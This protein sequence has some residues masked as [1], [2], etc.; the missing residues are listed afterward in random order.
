MSE[1]VEAALHAAGIGPKLKAAL[2]FGPILGFVA[3][4]LVVREQTYTLAGRDWD[5]FVL[6][7]GGFVPV[8]LAS[9]AAMWRLTG[10]ITPVQVL[11]LIIMTL[12]GALTVGFNDERFFK[13]RTTVV[14]L[15]LSA[16]L[17]VGLARGQAW[18]SGVMG[19]MVALSPAGWTYLTRRFAAV[20]LVLAGANE[21]I[22]RNF[23]TDV[24]VAYDTFIMPVA[25]FGYLALSI[26]RART[27]GPASDRP[28]SEPSEPLDAG[29]RET[30]NT[31]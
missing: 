11:T 13:M 6:L 27:L 1:P 21:A 8:V 17:W 14:C 15:T 7:V 4:Y 16:I 30:G 25:F 10:R 20:L 31:T 24:W 5:G 22:W 9:S 29:Q 18:L 2:E 28:A 12:S 19:G 26:R 23:S 3:V